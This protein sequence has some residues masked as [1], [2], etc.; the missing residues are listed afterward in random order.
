MLRK[1]TEDN[2]HRGKDVL[3]SFTGRINTNTVI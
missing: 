1:E 2:T 3:Y